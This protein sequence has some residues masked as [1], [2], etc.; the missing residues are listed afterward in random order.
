[1]D[2]R[3]PAPVVTGPDQVESRRTPVSRG[4]GAEISWRIVPRGPVSGQ[5]LFKVGGQQ[6]PKSIEAGRG[7]GSSQARA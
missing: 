6:I 1:M 3:S 7:R 4:G 2:A 5:L